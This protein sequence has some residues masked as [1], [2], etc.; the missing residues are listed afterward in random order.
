MAG[1]SNSKAHTLFEKNVFETFVHPGEVVEV[2][3]LS[4]K[5]RIDNENARGTITGYFDDHNAFCEAVQEI[6]RQSHSGIYS[7]LQVIDPRLLGRA[8]NR[9]KQGSVA[10]SDNNVIA[11]R[12]M[13]IDFDPMRPAGISSSGSELQEALKLRDTVTTWIAENLKYPNP[14]KAMSGN[15]GHLL[16]RLPDLPVNVDNQTFIKNTLEGLAQQ[17]NTDMVKIDTKVFNPAR[18]WKLYGTVARKGDELPGS[19]HRE[20]RPHRMAYI[21]D[22]GGN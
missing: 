17:F 9:V 16:Y 2:R 21:E 22:L 18:I 3:V 4:F 6:D 20:A 14:I 13:P 15:G 5:G 12:W 7:T 1:T 11:Y 8:N 10:T 19:E